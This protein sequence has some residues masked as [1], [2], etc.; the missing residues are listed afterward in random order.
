M[1]SQLL[2]G[3]RI[4]GLQADSKGHDLLMS[5]TKLSAIFFSC[6]VSLVLGILFFCYPLIFEVLAAAGANMRLANRLR[7]V[8]KSL[9]ESL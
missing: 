5:I 1:V 4:A 7:G 8:E 2:W 3:G 6:A 9:E